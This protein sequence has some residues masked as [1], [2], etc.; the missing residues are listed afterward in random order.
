MALWLG[1]ILHQAQWLALLLAP[2]WDPV[3]LA[4]HHLVPGSLD[5][6]LRAPVSLTSIHHLVPLQDLLLGL[7]SLAGNRVSF[8]LPLV[9][10]P[11]IQVR[12]SVQWEGSL[13][14]L[15]QRPVDSILTKCQVLSKSSRMIENRAL[16]TS[17]Q[18]NVLQ[19]PLS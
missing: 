9:V 16:A 15:Q 2:L 5:S 11:A 14:L 1:D 18:V 7:I 17:R 6:P 8:P 19:F 10:N 3:S 13:S 12:I 4:S